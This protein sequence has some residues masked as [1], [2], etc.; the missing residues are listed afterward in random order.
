LIDLDEGERVVSLARLAE[1]EDEDE[2]GEEGEEQPVV[3][4][5]PEKT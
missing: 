1:K 2:G 4:L 3:V 5:D